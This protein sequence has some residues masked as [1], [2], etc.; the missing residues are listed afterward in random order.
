MGSADQQV[1]QDLEF[2]LF[3][4]DRGQ[5][6]HKQDINKQEILQDAQSGGVRES[7]AED[8]NNGPREFEIDSR[9]LQEQG[10]NRFRVFTE[11]EFLKR[12]EQEGFKGQYDFKFSKKQRIEANL[13]ALR[14]TQVL[15]M[16]ME[17]LKAKDEINQV[18]IE[19]KFQHLNITKE[20]LNLKEFQ[21]FSFS[22][23]AIK[24]EEQALLAQYSGFGGL[25]DLFFNEE[26]KELENELKD[27][28]GEMYYKEIRESSF[29]A[30]YLFG[31]AKFRSAKG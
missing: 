27:L 20:E 30:Y 13:K 28:I 15:F 22:T 1:K 31:F 24:E 14:L 21:N 26:F 5:T 2:N 19:K 9:F 11:Y 3:T 29:N 18:A 4:D 16:R 7:Q 23:L 17:L 6:L 12:Y 10:S 25:R 8:R